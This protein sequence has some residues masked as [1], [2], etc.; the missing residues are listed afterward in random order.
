MC[1]VCMCVVCVCAWC[2]ACVCVVCVRLPQPFS[3]VIHSN[4][5]LAMDLHRF[6][7]VCGGH[8]YGVC[9]AFACVCCVY[10]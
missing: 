9:G 1:V 3:V 5:L 10:V 4:V 6:V 7:Y 8:V 2:V